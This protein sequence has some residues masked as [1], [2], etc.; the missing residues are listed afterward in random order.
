MNAVIIL[1]LIVTAYVPGAGG[2]NGGLTG[3]HCY[4]GEC[5]VL[6]VGDCACGPSF[7]FGVV[8]IV[9]GKP[10]I[11]Y[12]RGYAIGNYNIDLVYPNLESAY[13]W[14]RR[15]RQV[16][17]WKPKTYQRYRRELDRLEWQNINF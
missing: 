1:T 3:A 16:E 8:F 13:A 14:G 7:E 11:C 2:I 4:R 10:Y 9:D 15:T 12:D 6:E 5:R 17:V